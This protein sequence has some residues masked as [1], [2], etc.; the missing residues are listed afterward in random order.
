MLEW[1]EIVSSGLIKSTVQTG[2][3][4]DDHLIGTIGND[5]LTGGIGNDI[6]D[7]GAGNDT[8]SGGAGDD[9]YLFRAGSGRDTINNSG[10]GN[11]VLKF[12]DINP[13]EL[14]FGKSGSH[15]LIGLVGTDDQVTV[16]N[17]YANGDYKI[18]AIEA[19]G[20]ALIEN[21]V[22]LMVQAMS[23]IGV[24]GGIDGQWTDDQR[25]ALAPVLTSYW[26]PK[27]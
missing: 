12:E 4:G 10:G 15:L 9:I 17:W 18:D 22:A 25:D 7:G 16:N 19:G 11:D 13:A 21:Q 6:L 27:A 8:L 20:L 23:S 14:W 26:Q 3:T 5:T 1:H 24:P 2:G